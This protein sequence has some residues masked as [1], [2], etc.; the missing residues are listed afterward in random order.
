MGRERAQLE[1][2]VNTIQDLDVSLVDSRELLELAAGVLGRRY[3]VVQTW[4]TNC[5]WTSRKPSRAIR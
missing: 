5:G 3:F 2:V 1:Q 4:A